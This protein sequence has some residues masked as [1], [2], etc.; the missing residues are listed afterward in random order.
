MILTNKRE[1]GRI[2]IHINTDEICI[3][4]WFS[5]YDNSQNK[6]HSHINEAVHIKNDKG[7]TK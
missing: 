4:E 6:L 5:S 2:E 3:S 7:V 1:L